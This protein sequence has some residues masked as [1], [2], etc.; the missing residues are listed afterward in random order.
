MEILLGGITDSDIGSQPISREPDLYHP[1]SPRL[2]M[3][4]AR[5]PYDSRCNQV[6]GHYGVE[7][8]DLHGQVI[9]TFFVSPQE[10]EASIR[11]DLTESTTG[12]YRVV[13]TNE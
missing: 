10:S 5:K 3:H 12:F 9:E 8:I 7:E 4:F 1:S 2:S 11:F 6:F 13:A